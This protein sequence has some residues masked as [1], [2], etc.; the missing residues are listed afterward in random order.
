[1]RKTLITLLVFIAV[2]GTIRAFMPMGAKWYINRQLSQLDDYRGSVGDVDIALIRG[3]FQMQDVRIFKGTGNVPVPFLAARQVEISLQ[4]REVLRGKLVSEISLLRPEVNFV[5]GPTPKQSQKKVDSNWRE[6]I[7]DIVPV[8]INRLEIRDGEIHFRNLARK[9]PVDIY[10][11]NIDAEA[12]N[13]SNTAGRPGTL[14]ASL[15]ARGIAMNH[16]PFKLDVHLNALAE[17]IDFDLNSELRDLKLTELNDFF[18]AYAGVDIESGKLSVATEM[19]A[20]D[21]KLAGYIKPIMNNLD[22]VELDED[23]RKG[24]F[25][26]F[27]QSLTGTLADVLQ[28][29]DTQGAKIPIKGSLRKPATDV[30]SGLG[31]ALKHAFDEPLRPGLEK[32]ID[33]RSPASKDK[34]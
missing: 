25:A 12:H 30:L 1:M 10:M 32:S 7:E 13:L 14:P 19:A 15:K 23:T 11:K 4:W 28:S 9:P 5:D 33:I 20:K 2:L 29:D 6:V 27:W 17:P 24:P 21:G 3:G 18:R 34:K 31:S 26:L 8:T 22:V 16:A